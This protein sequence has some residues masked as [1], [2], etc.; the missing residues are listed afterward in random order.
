MWD[1]QKIYFERGSHIA[2]F[3]LRTT[4]GLKDG[5][6]NTMQKSDVLGMILNY[7]LLWGSNFRALSSVE[8]S[9]TAIILI[10]ETRTWISNLGSNP[11]RDCLRFTL[12]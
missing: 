5:A 12:R 4:K 6:Q 7:V 10:Q 3:V 2:S 11:R 9:F 1:S 8:N